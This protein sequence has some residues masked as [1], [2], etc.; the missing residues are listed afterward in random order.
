MTAVGIDNDLAA[1]KQV[2]TLAV[3]KQKG[4]AVFQE[5]RPLFGQKNLK[6]S[7][8]ESLRVDV[9]IGEVG[10]DGEVGDQVAAQAILEIES[11]CVQGLGTIDLVGAETRQR[12]GFEDQQ[13]S[14]ADIFQVRQFARLGDPLQAVNAQ[15]RLP[16]V[17]L[18]FPPDETP[19]N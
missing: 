7:W 16:Q 9:G 17:F 15:V 14:A 5:E 19:K 13:A 6:G 10:V 8:I 18:I 4:A 11:A 3:A 1:E 2:C 12:V